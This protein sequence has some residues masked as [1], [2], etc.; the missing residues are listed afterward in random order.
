MRKPVKGSTYAIT[1]ELDEFRSVT[2]T[3]RIDDIIDPEEPRVFFVVEVECQQSDDQAGAAPNY[4]KVGWHG[5]NNEIFLEDYIK[6]FC[7]MPDLVL[8]AARD[9]DLPWG[10]SGLFSNPK[11]AQKYA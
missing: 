11:Y 10:L 6:Q 8:E 7:P 1:R 5:F 9:L 2:I 4:W 3:V